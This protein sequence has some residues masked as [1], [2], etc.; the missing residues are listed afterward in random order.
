MPSSFSHRFC[1]APMLDWTD[2]HERYFLRTLSKHVYLY[3]EMVTTGALIYGDS[4]RHLAYNELEHPVALQLGGSQPKEIAHCAV[5]AEKAGYDEVNLNIG[6]PSDRVQSGRFGACLMAQPELVAQC[7][8]AIED[9]VQIP[10]TI[11]CR[12]GIDEHDSDEFL[13]NFVESIA[14]AGCKTF[15]VHAR[16]AIL[17]GLSPK[18]NREIPPLQYDR[19]F[20]LKERFPHLKIIIN[21]GIQKLEAAH[22]LLNSVDGVMI[23]RE[24]YQNPWI[25]ANV[26]ELFF[27]GVNQHNNRFAV[28]SAFLPYV[29]EELH[30][31]TPLQHMTR[32]ILGLFH[33]VPGGKAFRR[34][35]SENAFRKDA[36]VSVLEDAVSLVVGISDNDSRS[37]AMVSETLI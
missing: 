28:I 23:G 27:G 35:L 3:T 15:I 26:D 8:R 1:V 20:R 4:Q 33:G 2:R 36:G 32:H 14:A 21:G 16:I 12:I 7:I 34:H 30:S 13:F 19:V 31:G 10:A 18:E 17:K 37:L 6:C 24:V 9:C 29:K 22:E 5:L 11:K 25:L